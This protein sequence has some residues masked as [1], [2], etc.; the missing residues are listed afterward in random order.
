[1]V[2]EIQIDEMLEYIWMLEEDYGKPES[3][4]LAEKFGNEIAREYIASMEVKKLI[5]L[6]DT[7]IVFTETGKKRAGLIIRRHRIAE[8]LLNDVL[9]MRGDEFEKGACQ[10][11][12][13]VNEE[14][15]ASICTLL[16]HPS[17]CPHGKKIPPGDCCLSAKK[18]L[19]PVI[20]P[21]STIKAGKTVKV[22]YIS[23]KSHTSLDR[24]TGIGVIPGLELAI[25]QK[26]PSMIL[27]YGETELALDNDIAKN[28]FVRIINN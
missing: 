13:F 19:E 24:L 2:D 21:L 27:Q 3:I 4:R 1:M 5:N 25:H 28:V 16:G 8:R 11:E 26:F 18:N 6:N 14:I 23:T 22:V 17:I 15:I 20:S 9:D 7:N 10:F 12:H